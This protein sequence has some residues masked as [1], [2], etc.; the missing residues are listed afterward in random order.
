MMNK[1]VYFTMA[2]MVH[3]ENASWEPNTAT[4]IVISTIMTTYGLV[5]EDSS[6]E[7]MTIFGQLM[8]IAYSRYYDYFL[9]KKIVDPHVNPSSIT[10]TTSEKR[11]IWSLFVNAF[12][13]TAPR[14]IP[15]LKSY[16]ANESSP[17]AK[18]E[19]IT[20]GINK[21]NDTPQG[22]GDYSDDTHTTTINQ[23]QVNVAADSGSIVERLDGLYKN[24][25]S[26]LREWTNEFRC[27]F[28]TKL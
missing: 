11:L 10:F 23:N 19:S 27:L 4:D 20:T 16:L 8:R 22:S 1:V 12:N 3:L 14:Y 2:D 5:I 21:F 24:W 28:Y 26:V 17:I 25:R 6:T 15:L 9:S 13:I 7:K 18:I